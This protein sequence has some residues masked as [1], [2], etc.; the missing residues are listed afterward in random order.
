LQD[1][2][3][4]SIQSIYELAPHLAEKPLPPRKPTP[5]NP[6]DMG[7]F[8]L[9]TIEKM[10]IPELAKNYDLSEV[11]VWGICTVVRKRMFIAS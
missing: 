9:H 4:K 10:T 7:I 1:I 11:S 3:L 5:V 6:G 2:N 8:R